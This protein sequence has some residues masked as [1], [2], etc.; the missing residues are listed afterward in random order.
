MLRSLL[1]LCLIAAF[2][3]PAAAQ[4]APLVQVASAAENTETDSGTLSPAAIGTI[5]MTEG[6][7][8]L[9]LRAAEDNKAYPVKGGD[10]LY[11]KDT[12]QT[13]PA[14]KILV[15]MIDD[16]RFT[17]GENT[18]L[19]AEEYEFDDR[20]AA[21]SKAHYAVP[22]GAFLYA[23]GA[24]S[25]NATQNN[26]RIQ[27]PNGAVNVQTA[28]VWGGSLDDQY[29]VYVAG[30]DA[31]LETNRGRIRLADG[32]GTTIRSLNAIPER[33]AIWGT[34]RV[35]RAK[36]SIT[37]KDLEGAKEKISASQAQHPDMVLRHKAYRN[38]AQQNR[39][40]Q[41]KPRDSIKR[42]DN[43]PVAAAD[44]VVAD[45]PA[46]PI[47]AH[48]PAAPD[49]TA[50]AQEAIM[51][52]VSTPEPGPVKTLNDVSAPLPDA[53]PTT[54]EG[55]ASAA[56]PPKDNVPPATP[57]APEPAAEPQAVTTNAVTPSVI[58]EAEKPVE[59]LPVER[60]DVIPP[61]FPAP[62]PTVQPAPEDLPADP[63]MRQEALEKLNLHNDKASHNPF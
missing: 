4:T 19:R 7:G 5:I 59:N 48:D 40:E 35:D 14:A 18:R 43:T 51:P 55:T 60:N 3:V 62:A 33:P 46:A 17:L 63:A 27:T 6:P 11:P 54:S 49:E 9:I 39:I 12:V 42:L 38:A 58:L 45:S 21:L 37:L 44:P 24:I 23:G 2:S 15:L 28:T 47:I 20:N 31:I 32:E 30:G 34:V 53:V 1:S 8:N 41:Q 10:V 25:K 56:A 57:T 29:H 50:A 61:A 26:V 16:S 22:Q 36:E 13:G 52:P